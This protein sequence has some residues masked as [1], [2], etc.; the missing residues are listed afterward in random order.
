MQQAGMNEQWTE[1]IVPDSNLFDLHLKEV[2]RYRDLLQLLVKRDFVA[3]YKQTILGPL[4]FLLQPILITITFVII[5]GRIAK[6]STDGIPMTVFYLSG[7]T[8]W[9]YFSECFSKTSTVFKDNAGLLGKVYFPRLIIPLSIAISAFIKFGLQFFLFLIIWMY[10]L[11]F[12]HSTI[13]PNWYILFTPILIIFL[14]SLT[15]GIGM[16]VSSIT[17][18]Y[19][20]LILMLAFIIQLMMYATPIIY[21]LSAVDGKYKWLILANPMTAMLEMFRYAFF[22]KGDF[23]FL[24]ILYSISISILCLVI[25]T[26]SFNKVEKTFMD[27]V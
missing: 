23:S 14:S 16:F 24:S 9:N 3:N 19:R 25:G 17:I 11:L 21:P 10:Y 8:F 15:L 20:D 5:F 2:W 7:I 27:T 22:G 13:H 26:F 18:K 1:I 6:L 12:T 4:W